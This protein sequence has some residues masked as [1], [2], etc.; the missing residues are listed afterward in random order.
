MS[1][2]LSVNHASIGFI[3]RNQLRAAF[4]EINPSVARM[5]INKN[6]SIYIHLLTQKVQD[7]KYQSEPNERVQQNENH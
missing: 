2:K 5:I 3:N 1:G 6:D 7:P 4:H